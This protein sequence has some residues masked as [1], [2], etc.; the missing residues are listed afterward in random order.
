M[1]IPQ[2]ELRRLAE[3][4]KVVR[5]AAAADVDLSYGTCGGM[6]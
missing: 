1:S 5:S 6:S 3:Q 2:H 4:R